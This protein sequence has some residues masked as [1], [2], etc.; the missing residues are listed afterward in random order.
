[1]IEKL[2]INPIKTELTRELE[3][4]IGKKIGR[5]DRFLSRHARKSAHAKV[6]LKESGKGKA[7]NLECEVIL[8]VPGKTLTAKETTTNMFS[9]IDIVESKL[10]RQLRKYKEMHSNNRGK[11][12]ARKVAARFGR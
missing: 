8:K 12:L 7:R 11:R 2:E 5:L 4:Y 3:K 6:V 1:M 9:S 10:I